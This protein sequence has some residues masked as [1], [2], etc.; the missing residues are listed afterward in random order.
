MGGPNKQV[1]QDCDILEDNFNI[2]ITQIITRPECNTETYLQVGSLAGTSYRKHVGRAVEKRRNP[3]EHPDQ[4]LEVNR[5]LKTSVTVKV[6]A[7]GKKYQNNFE[8]DPLKC[9]D[10]NVG[11]K[12]ENGEKNTIFVNLKRGGAFSQK[13]FDICLTHIEIYDQDK[14]EVSFEKVPGHSHR[15]K[16]TSLNRVKN[17]TLTVAYNFR[18][19]MTKTKILL[20]PSSEQ[21]RVQQPDS[22]QSANKSAVLTAIICSSVATLT[23]TLSIVAIVV[24]FIRCKKRRRNIMKVDRNEDYGFYY[25]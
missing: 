16:I 24:V 10:S 7:D 5:C 21:L 20:V 4:N 12:S 14:K 2:A 19:N 3:L 6:E 15:V 25:T 1:I 8:L 22:G 9:F 11:L 23:V 17:Q 18:G 13:L